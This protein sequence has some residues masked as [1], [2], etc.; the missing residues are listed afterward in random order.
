MFVSA[1]DQ[2]VLTISLC[3]TSLRCFSCV[4]SRPWR[5]RPQT[6]SM[7]NVLTTTEKGFSFLGICIHVL[8]PGLDLLLVDVGCAVSNHFQ[9]LR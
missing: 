3:G 8:R 6:P 5:L 7:K 2:N 1:S 4:W 9:P